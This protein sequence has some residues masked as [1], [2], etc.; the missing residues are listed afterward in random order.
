V[1]ARAEEAAVRELLAAG[2]WR[3]VRGTPTAEEAAALAVVLGAALARRAGG[4]TPGGTGDETES[5]VRRSVPWLR[6][7]AGPGATTATSWV[8]GPRPGWSDAA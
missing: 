4:Q 5:G 1:T 6:P 7:A 8:A 2:A 3:V